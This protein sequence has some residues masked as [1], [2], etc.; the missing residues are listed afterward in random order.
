MPLLTPNPPA[1]SHPPSPP[2]TQLPDNKLH[3]E[4]LQTPVQPIAQRVNIMWAIW[5][6]KK[7]FFSVAEELS[8]FK[9]DL[10]DLRIR[11]RLDPTP[12][13]KTSKSM[14]SHQIGMPRSFH[15]EG[16]W[17][18]VPAPFC[19]QGYRPPVVFQKMKQ[20]PKKALINHY[21]CHV[22]IHK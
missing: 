4:L 2:S 20:V 7:G 17:E 21:I 12:G 6:V 14:L 10:T 19:W 11:V 13:S 16:R 9:M 1:A 5:K 3:R 18:R 8:A 15:E 22:Q